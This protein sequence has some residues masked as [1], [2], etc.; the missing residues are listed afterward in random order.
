MPSI[1]T[2]VESNSLSNTSTL[3]VGHRCALTGACVI[4]TTGADAYI[5]LFDV[6]T[7]AAVTVGTTV[8]TWVIQND[9]GKGLVNESSNIPEGGI[10]F[11][12]GI[13]AVSTTTPTG[14]TAAVQ[15]L[16]VSIF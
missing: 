16:K 5:Q 7:A 6:A 13:A 10:D 9:Y 15:H 8:P 2:I 12:N 1:S 4:N 3:L 11:V 14:S